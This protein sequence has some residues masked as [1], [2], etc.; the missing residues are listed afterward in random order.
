[1][2]ADSKRDIIA[3]NRLAL[4]RKAVRRSQSI[5]HADDEL[6][7]QKMYRYATVTRL[8]H[9]TAKATKVVKEP[10]YYRTIH[11]IWLYYQANS[12]EYGF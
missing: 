8:N 1:M 4:R 9:H 10:F 6:A 3:N 7:I 5:F 2:Q 11:E 12:R